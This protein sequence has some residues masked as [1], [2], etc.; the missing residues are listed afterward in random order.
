MSDTNY[1]Q[2]IWQQLINQLRDDNIITSFAFDNFF[3]DTQATEVNTSS[4]IVEAPDSFAVEWLGKYQEH[5][6]QLLKEILGGE[7]KVFFK[8][9]YLDVPQLTQVSEPSRPH[10]TQES[11]LNEDGSINPAV[12]PMNLEQ[13]LRHANLNPNYTFSN[14][15]AG[16]SNRLAY[17]TAFAVAE[18]PGKTTYNPLFLYGGSG[19]GKTH[20]VQA[21]GNYILTNDPTKKIFYITSELFLSEYI[22]SIKTGDGTDFRDKYREADV[23][24]IDDIQFFV[25]KEKIQE[26]FFHTFNHL[27]QLN[28]QIIITSDSEPSEL[29]TLT[30]R[31]VTRFTW[32][33]RADIQPPELEMRMA[34]LQKKIELLDD[35]EDV[36]EE[37]IQYIATNVDSN[38]RELEGALNSLFA[39]ALMLG[40]LDITLDLAVE[41]L[42][43]YT[44]KDNKTLTIAKIQKSVAKYFHITPDDLKSKLRREPLA[45]QRHI[46]IYLCKTLTDNSLKKIGKEFGN[47]DHT[48]IINSVAQAEKK[49]K[50]EPDTKAVITELTNLLTSN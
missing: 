48:T 17:T 12:E 40:K 6:E 35:E 20:L 32:G 42:R 9:K 27:H 24:I 10:F 33:I 36:P 5:V 15:V 1:A 21:I 30:D 11:I 39:H 7:L 25:G 3:K 50:K 31:L 14:F 34:I 44:K 13:R 4:L 2:K 28:K 49:L 45:T 22:K 47:R 26:E 23:L 18:K 46:A 41:A 8:E 19:L 29:S 16:D 43:N 37:V 38:V